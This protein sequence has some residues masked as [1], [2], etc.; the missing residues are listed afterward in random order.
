MSNT[1]RT[2]RYT[3]LWYYSYVREFT[4][5]TDSSVRHHAT[6]RGRIERPSE[7]YLSI[8]PSTT[9]S[10]TTTYY[11]QT[12]TIHKLNPTPPQHRRTQGK[13]ASC[14]MYMENRTEVQSVNTHCTWR[15][16]PKQLSSSTHTVHGE[17]HRSAIQSTQYN[18]WRTTNR[19]SAIHQ[20]NTTHGEPLT[21]A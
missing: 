5:H 9:L 10:R 8:N 4:H 13:A 6:T 12:S 2:Q 21:K 19:S 15:V 11:T 1:P 18:T 14:K 17:P 16:A 20:H 3:T 7:D